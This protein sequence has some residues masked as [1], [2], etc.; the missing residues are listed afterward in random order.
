MQGNTM[1]KILFILLTIQY[2]LF[3]LLNAA[4]VEA[5]LSS[6]EIVAGNMAQLKIQAMG[7][8]AAFPNIREIGGSDVLG[9][10]E[11]S[12]NS[13]SYINGEMKSERSTTLVLTFTPQK[14]MTIP[15]YTVNIDGKEYQTKPMDLKV[16]EPTAPAAGSDSK[17]SLQL[18][19][20]KR[21]VVVGEPFLAT[22]YFSLQNGVR[23][24]DNPQYNKP[25]FK[26]FFVKEVG[27]E[28]KYNEGKRQVTELRYIL[29]AKSEGNFTL[30]P[31]TAKIGVADRNRRD[32]FGRFFGTTWH[33]IA[34]N[35]IEVEVKAKSEDTDLVG[36]FHL[37]N[38]LDK[39]RV[40]AN[41][42]VNL[43][44]K[45][46]GEGSLEDFEYPLYEI[47]GVTIYSDDAKIEV[48]LEEG[49][50][51]STYSK[52]FAFISDH[53][54]TVPSRSITVYDTKRKKVNTLEI[55]SYD[56]HIEGG[57]KKGKIASSAHTAPNDIGKVQT[58]LEIPEK[59]MLDSDEKIFNEIEKTEWWLL[60][61]AFVSGLFVMYLF[62]FIPS[63]K[64][65]SGR[66]NY[67]ESDALKI[68]YP[69][70]NESMEIEK[71]VRDLYAKQR[72][73]KTVMIDKK[74][75]RGMIEKINN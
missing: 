39:Q 26:G 10:H 55:A 64:P 47:D 1:K 7:K 4:S 23:L 57:A 20:E 61:L 36:N 14:D 34:S 5:T 68:L 74:I 30:G 72:G 35:A 59:S 45:I 19:S 28:K 75:L 11:S 18:R 2:A 46:S 41:K 65:R 48:V 66:T 24:S 6:T 63:L 21:S 8:R 31:A 13:F 32:M 29:V 3:T 50:I 54:F 43:T 44:V 49:K 56:I 42:P 71:M 25:E 53:D 67:K 15:A 9:R 17:Y 62:R 52:S 70:I 27:E 38:S 69:H 37:E 51:K 73:D 16:V 12:N 60:L 22:V 58:N 33:P 40:K